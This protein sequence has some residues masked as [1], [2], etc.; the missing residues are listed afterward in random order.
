MALRFLGID[1]DTGTA[2]SPTVWVDEQRE[3]F[4]FQGWKPSPELEAECAAVEIP[5]HAIGIPD[6]EAVIR[7][8]VRMAQMIREACAVAERAKL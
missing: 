8:P 3:E 1:P 5:G 2:N 7:S 4:V 6:G